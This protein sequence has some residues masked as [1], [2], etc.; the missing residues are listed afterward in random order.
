MKRFLFSI[1]LFLTHSTSHADDRDLYFSAINDNANLTGKPNILFIIDTSDSMNKAVTDSHTTEYVPEYEYMPS[2]SGRFS[3]N[4]YWYATHSNS[5]NP[6]AYNRTVNINCQ[7]ISYA[8]QQNYIYSGPASVDSYGNINCTAGSTTIYQ[9][10]L[11]NYLNWLQIGSGDVGLRSR[12]SIVKDA[13]K[14]LISNLSG[15]NIGIMRFD[16][17]S[18]GNMGKHGGAVIMQMQPVD[19]VK[20]LAIST[21][22][23]L[24]AKSFTPLTETLDEARRYFYGL[25]P[26]YGKG[27]YNNTTTS[28]SISLA[29]NADGSY[30]SPINAACQ[31]NHLVLFTDGVASED[32]DSQATVK[33]LYQSLSTSNPEL[34]P[35]KTT[36][37]CTS[38]SGD[39]S[40]LDELTYYLRYADA[41]SL[42]GQ[43][44]ITSHMIG[45]FLG[46]QD[47]GFLQQAANAGGGEFYSANDPNQLAAAL[48]AIIDGIVSLD[49]TFTAPAVSAS[50]ANRLTHDSSLYFSLFRPVN[51]IR[52]PGNLKKY[53]MGKDGILYGNNLSTPAINEKTGAFSSKV[54]DLWNKDSEPDGQKTEAGGAASVINTQNNRT[55]YFNNNNALQNISSL[56]P[57][58]FLGANINSEQLKSWISGIDITDSDGDN[59]DND[60]RYPIGDPLHSE[61][62]I[63]SY[64][65]GEPLIFF[66]DNEGYLHAINSISGTE[67]Y[68]F[69]PQTLLKNQI[70][71]MQNTAGYKDKPYG[72]D[73][74]I[75]VFYEKNTAN[76]YLYTGLRRGG[77]DYYALDI[78]QRSAPKFLFKIE[79]GAGDFERLGQTW[80]KAMPT[81]IKLNNEIIPVLIISGGY[82]PVNENNPAWAKDTIGNAIYIVDARTG[83]R[84]WWASNKDADVNHSAMQNSIPASAAL[85][86]INADDLLDY[87]YLADTG[88]HIFRVDINNSATSASD[89][90][91]VTLLASLGGDTGSGGFSG[92]E[93]NRKFYTTPSIAFWPDADYGDF[94]SIAVGSGLRETPRSNTVQDHFYVLRDKYPY[95][96]NQP[97]N[98]VAT[99]YAR[100]YHKNI[101][102][103]DSALVN[104]S[105]PANQLDNPEYQQITAAAKKQELLK[106]LQ[107]ADAWYL[108]LNKHDGEKIVSEAITFDGSVMFSSFA[109]SSAAKQDMCTVDLGRSQFY[110]LDLLYGSATLDLDGD[111]VITLNDLKKDLHSTGM[112]PRP[113]V[114]FREDNKRSIAPGTEP[115][116]DT[117]YDDDKTNDD[118][119]GPGSGD[120]SR[121]L[122]KKL[123]WREK[124]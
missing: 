72:M 100:I 102:Q 61:P 122:L 81:N 83:T 49:S 57:N 24:T 116:E 70:I 64:S 66:G 105:L 8:L 98:P 37:N 51:K 90:A 95:P 23:N 54:S 55:I 45:G 87:F 89:L 124:M 79:G 13:F 111:G 5:K 110:A 106:K 123:Y 118:G 80:A 26:V 20:Q 68:A 47:S 40:C 7:A 44:Y 115:I 25:N 85:V 11:G 77:R 41:S 29:M 52:W 43:Q 99:S 59:D 88:G 101:P 56:D 33:N 3:K 46:A 14:K 19:N 76:K 121:I 58:I 65:S 74:L 4:E 114:I 1:I 93:N 34:P 71:Y 62:K 97:K 35:L 84:L 103:G 91:K 119:Q 21:V 107:K 10:A 96:K 117:R 27:S 28:K 42:E 86:D 39:G 73:G 60:L 82:D 109:N 94:I 75:S 69:I 30:H 112:V 32:R 22:E 6:S 50:S 17:G 12:L 104:I 31:M 67:E 18:A 38:T 2:T 113:V 15:V 53:Q 9:I 16:E 36:S 120:R 48:Q 108:Q 92:A 78:S 63:V